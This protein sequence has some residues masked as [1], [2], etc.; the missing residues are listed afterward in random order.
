MNMSSSN[1][2]KNGRIPGILDFS[3]KVVVER[4]RVFVRSTLINWFLLFYLFLGSLYLALWFYGDTSPMQGHLSVVIVGN[5]GLTLLLATLWSRSLSSPGSMMLYRTHK[6]LKTVKEL[7]REL[8]WKSL[9]GLAV[10]AIVILTFVLG[11]IVTSVNLYSL[12]SAN[13]LQGAKRI[14][15]AL[16]NPQLGILQQV[17]TAMVETV[18]IAF[19]AT[20][21]A[22]PISFFAAFF[23]ARNLMRSSKTGLTI[24]SVLRFICNFTRSVE[25]L[26]WAIIFSVWVGIGPFAGM[27][28]LMLHSVASL[29]KL[30]SEQIESI[31]QGPIEAIEATGA[32]PVQVV[33][34]AVVPQIV[35]PYLGFTIYRWDINIRMATVIGLVG[36]GGIGTLLNQYQGLAM[37]NE[38]GTIVIVIACVVWFMDYLSAKIREAIY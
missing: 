9:T 13:G 27:L 37:W 2:Q 4:K 6:M 32:N 18:F 1:A 28:S 19:L 35:L 38:I 30:Y 12:F 21:M 34:Y 10:A 25:P 22:I 5:A 15:M 36:G 16:L 17:L 3:Q 24:Y 11:W 29:I 8:K 33:W 31:N 20:F 7:R 14:F 26:V 23:A